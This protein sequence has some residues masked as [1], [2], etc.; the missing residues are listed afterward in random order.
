MLLVLGAYCLVDGLVKKDTQ[1]ILVALAIVGY[2]IVSLVRG[3]KRTP[4]N[5]NDRNTAIPSTPTD[6][7][8]SYRYA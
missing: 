8:V 7:F 5:K 4:A 1:E 3:R 6:N 2:T